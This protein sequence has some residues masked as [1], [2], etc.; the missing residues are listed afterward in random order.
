MANIWPLLFVLLRKS[1]GSVVIYS[2]MLISVIYIVLNRTDLLFSKAADK[3]GSASHD[4]CHG[5]YRRRL[6]RPFAATP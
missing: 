1:F 6:F 3:F 5:V 4:P 2:G